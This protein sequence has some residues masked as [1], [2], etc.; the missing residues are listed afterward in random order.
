MLKSKYY[1]T[2]SLE[3]YSQSAGQEIPNHFIEPEVLLLCLQVPADGPFPDSH[4]SSPH[5]PTFSP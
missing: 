3:A 4:E 2:P 5:P 1:P